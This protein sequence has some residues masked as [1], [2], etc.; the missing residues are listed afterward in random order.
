MIIGVTCIIYIIT[1]TTLKVKTKVL[2]TKTTK[3]FSN[4]LPTY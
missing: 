1:I 2:K 4:K 3:N